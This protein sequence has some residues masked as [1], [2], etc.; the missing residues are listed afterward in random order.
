M[1]FLKGYFIFFFCFVYVVSVA[2]ETTADFHICYFSLNNEKEF[3]EMQKFTDKLNQYSQ[4]SFSVDEYMPENGDP[5][6]SFQKLIESGVRCDGLVLSG[7]HTGSFGGDRTIGSLGINFLE[8][9]SCNDQYSEWFENIKALWL[10]GCRTLGTGDIVHAEDENADHH[11][12]RVGRVLDEDG[13]EQSFADL[14]VE[15]SATLDPDNPLASRYLRVFP[16][17]TTFGWTKT[18]PGEL[19][20]S[21]YS[22]PF[23][24]AHVSRLIN[25]QRQFPEDSPIEDDWTIESTAQYRTALLNLLDGGRQDNDQN[26]ITRAWKNHGSVMEGLSGYGYFNT[27]L[28]SYKSLTSINDEVLNTAKLYVCLLQNTEEE[29][30]FESL[31]FILQ[32]P[33]LIRYTYN[34]LLGRLYSLEFQNPDFHSQVIQI[35]QESERMRDFL[36]QKFG[37]KSLGVIMQIDYFA[38]YEEIYGE[39]HRIRSIILEK[40]NEAFTKI[41]SDSYDEVDYKKTLISSLSKHGYLNSEGGIQ[42]LSQAIEDSSSDIRFKAIIAVRDMGEVGLPIVEKAFNDSNPDI[43]VRAVVRAGRIGQAGLPII[44]QAIED[45]NVSVRL[46][47]A[48]S[49]PESIKEQASSSLRQT[50]EQ[51]AEL[52]PFERLGVLSA[53]AKM[54]ESTL[55][56]LEEAFKNSKT[57]GVAVMS[58]GMIGEAGLPIL[59]EAMKDSDFRMRMTAVQAARY[60]GEKG[61]PI[62]KQAVKDPNDEVRLTA[63]R[64]IDHIS[65]QALLTVRE[66][67]ENSED[68]KRRSKVLETAAG[69]G[70]EVL[71][72]LRQAFKSS[73]SAVRMEV[74]R[75]TAGVIIEKGEKRGGSFDEI[76]RDDPSD[77]LSIRFGWDIQKKGLSILKRGFEDPNLDVRQVTLIAVDRKVGALAL[78]VLKR[79]LRSRKVDDQTKEDI[80]NLIQTLEQHS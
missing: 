5:E 27:D 6:E 70:E 23:H 69:I 26:F 43:R 31:D 8:T 57:N 47:G 51:V 32:D 42:L 65:H 72:I 2:A 24:I 64:E 58:A 50:L 29:E 21:E 9:L 48:L 66:V 12:T 52:S 60:Q 3:T 39:N 80:R 34:S 38:L 44:Q 61:L 73:S 49:A 13:L 79:T 59:R 53:F 62:F 45:S 56:I 14:N 67:F 33:I 30:F 19:A 25:H 22:I 76:G 41:P 16:F 78:P 63:V 7:H 40:V 20:R 17:A 28:N 68:S 1:K 54:G 18:S 36:S 46:Q 74:V 37:Q 15:F 75:Q 35:L 4:Y 10:Q 11:T 77:S 71:S 55:P